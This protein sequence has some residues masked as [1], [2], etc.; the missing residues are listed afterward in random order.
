MNSEPL[1]RRE[2]ESSI[3]DGAADVYDQ[4]GERVANVISEAAK[5]EKLKSVKSKEI[6]N[7]RLK[8]AAEDFSTWFISWHS[9]F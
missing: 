3:T 8:A 9:W 2:K 6:I 1:L 5:S 7:S 4:N